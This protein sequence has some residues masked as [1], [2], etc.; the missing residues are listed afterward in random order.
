MSIGQLR[1]LAQCFV[2]TGESFVQPALPKQN[3]PEIA[4]KF[5]YFWV[6]PHG[7]LATGQRLVEPPLF[8]QSVA[9]I[10]MG[11][12][13]IR[14]Q[15]HGFAMARY[16][17][18]DPTHVDQDAA[19]VGVDGGIQ[20]A[21]LACPPKASASVGIMLLAAKCIPQVRQSVDEVRLYSQGMLIEGNGFPF[22]A[23][24][25]Q[26]NAQVEQSRSI[27]RLDSQGLPIARHGFRQSTERRQGEGE[28]AVI[29]IDG[30]IDRHGSLDVFNGQIVPA[31]LAEQRASR[32]QTWAWRGSTRRISRY[33]DSACARF[34]C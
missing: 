29:S 33:I 26:D 19:Q 8:Q 6:Q 10:A 27:V 32:F 1:I 30:R 28:I 23:H 31:A 7:L 13:Q 20:R 17:F 9:K 5:G 3:R 22:L 12:G 18:I 14:A 21:K 34:P 4:V 2:T 15:S 24:S 16:A 11:F 25:L